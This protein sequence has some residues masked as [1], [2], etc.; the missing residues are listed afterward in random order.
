MLEGLFR[1]ARGER[2]LERILEAVSSQVSEA[3]YQSLQ[4]FITCSPWDSHELMKRIG[5]QTNQLLDH[6][7]DTA[8]IIDEKAHLKKGK[9]SV[10]VG[11][12]YAGLVG[13]N[14][15]CQVGVYGA[16]GY[17]QYVGLVNCRLFL[18]EKWCHDADRC[19]KAGIPKQAQQY[20]TKLALA[21]EML[22]ESLSSGIK[23]GWVS[24][25]S[26]Y[27]RSH[28]FCNAIED[29]GQRFILDIPVVT[30]VY[31]KA[32]DIGLP[33]PRHKRLK[34]DGQPIKVEDYLQQLAEEDFKYIKIRKTTKGWLKAKIH[35]VKVWVWDQGDH[36]KGAEKQAR[37]RTLIIRKPCSKNGKIK[38]S[39]SNFKIN[40]CTIERFAFMQSQRY[41]VEKAF[42]EASKDLG[43][44][45]YQIRKY[46]S[47]YHFQALTM[48]AMLFVLKEIL[49]NREQI[50]LLS[51]LDLKKLIQCLWDENP[52]KRMLRIAQLL[53]RHHKRQN[54]IDRYY[55]SGYQ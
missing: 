7:Q 42:K 16:L 15:N 12:Q 33:S 23:F 10:G 13:K 26:L 46:N 39:L 40:E 34:A 52:N 6:W 25:D 38:I 1:T 54:D 17:E 49:R 55:K 18:P 31:L 32:P 47:W 48:L 5:L 20:K 19:K 36:G 51:Y 22:G 2:N 9:C 21:L 41:L 44:S 3:E 14:E 27:G 4:H 53:K 28:H 35:V 50:P 11:N 8:Y 45:D 43:M 24:A 37:E 29:M 30:R